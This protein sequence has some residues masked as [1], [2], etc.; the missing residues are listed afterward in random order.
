MKRII[1]IFRKKEKST[2]CDRETEID[3][4][5]QVVNRKR[6]N[7]SSTKLSQ[8]VK[9]EPS[10]ADLPRDD[11]GDGSLQESPRQESA[12]N[13]ARKTKVGNSSECWDIVPRTVSVQNESSEVMV[14]RSSKNISALKD[15]KRMLDPNTLARFAAPEP[16]NNFMHR[17][18]TIERLESEGLYTLYE[19]TIKLISEV[20]E[21]VGD[22]LSQLLSPRKVVATNVPSLPMIADGVHGCCRIESAG[23]QKLLPSSQMSEAAE[24]EAYV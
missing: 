5:E 6:M 10:L 4:K 16:L 7:V 17:L 24:T 12:Q 21:E 20:S 18:P 22:Q 13:S 23:S 2:K 14:S 19:P 11:E 8:K 1:R 9:E 15:V 3:G